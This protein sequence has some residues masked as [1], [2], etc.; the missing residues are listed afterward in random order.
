MKNAYLNLAL[1]IGFIELHVDLIFF[2]LGLVRNDIKV[3]AVQFTC[4]SQTKG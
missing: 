2:M 1:N 4:A 3:L